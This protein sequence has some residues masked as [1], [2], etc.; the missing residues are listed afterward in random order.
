MKSCKYRPEKRCYWSSC[1]I[2][3]SSS[4]N[5]AVCRFHPNPSGMLK[6][7][8]VVHAPEPVFSKHLRGG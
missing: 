1:S 7:R 4:G 8:L 6:H 3:D 5:V 2:F